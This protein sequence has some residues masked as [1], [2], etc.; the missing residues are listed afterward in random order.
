MESSSRNVIGNNFQ[1]KICEETFIKIKTLNQHIRNVHGEAKRF[2]CDV[3]NRIFGKKASHFHLKKHHEEG[4]KKFNCDSC[5][6]SFT[7]SAYLKKHT[8]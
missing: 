4:I 5:G 1:C 8:Y 3:C 2:V 7:E 6:K